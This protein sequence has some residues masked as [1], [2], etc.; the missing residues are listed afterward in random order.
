VEPSVV[1]LGDAG[2]SE[3]CVCNAMAAYHFAANR[4]GR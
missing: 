1:Q 4:L 3:L 2:Q